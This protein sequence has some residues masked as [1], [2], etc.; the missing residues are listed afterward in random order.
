[1]G[2]STSHRGAII[3]IARKILDEAN[4][5][6]F[7]NCTIIELA[8]ELGE[9]VSEH[10]QLL[11]ALR[12]FAELPIGGDADTSLFT[13]FDIAHK[14]VLLARAAIAKATGGAA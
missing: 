6:D 10:T 1:M 12:V 13:R 9:L 4:R 5:E 14:H 7:E 3:S 2:K 8:E 11:E